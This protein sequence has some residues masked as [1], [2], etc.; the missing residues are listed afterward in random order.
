ME[1]SHTKK[2]KLLMGFESRTSPVELLQ[3]GGCGSG[4]DSLDP[5]D[6]RKLSIGFIHT[7][8]LTCLCFFVL[9]FFCCVATLSS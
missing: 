5:R 2:F 9:L 4:I 7:S 8:I 3:K 6:E 1:N